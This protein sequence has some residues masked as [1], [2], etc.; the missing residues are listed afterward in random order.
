M[1]GA[2]PGRARLSDNSVSM[3]GVEGEGTLSNVAALD[4]R[5]MRTL[6]GFAL[7]AARETSGSGSRG[8]ATQGQT[9]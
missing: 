6:Y 2:T 1:R 8:E 7:S 9:P 3:M 5:P 4:T